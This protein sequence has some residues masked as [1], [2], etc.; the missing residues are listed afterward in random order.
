[1]PLAVGVEDV[2]ANLDQLAHLL[3][4]FWTHVIGMIVGRGADDADGLVAGNSLLGD[5]LVV[6]PGRFILHFV[7]DT[8]TSEGEL[9]GIAVIRSLIDDAANGLRIVR[10]LDSIEYDLCPREL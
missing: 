5:H 3:G 7:G 6:I 8:V 10:I 1:M 9:A 4:P 2:P